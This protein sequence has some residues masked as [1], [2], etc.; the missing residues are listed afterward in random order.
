[1]IEYILLYVGVLRDFGFFHSSPESSR[2]REGANGVATKP[3][4]LEGVRFQI[5][6]DS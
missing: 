1:M 2:K 3:E 5:P 4:G 6:L